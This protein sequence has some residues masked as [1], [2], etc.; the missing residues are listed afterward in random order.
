MRVPKLS[1]PRPQAVK[2][3]ALPPK[4]ASTGEGVAHRGTF[5]ISLPP[6]K[7]ARVGLELNKVMEA[8]G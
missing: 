2:A 4:T 8:T 3:R 5:G 6:R 1:K 7:D